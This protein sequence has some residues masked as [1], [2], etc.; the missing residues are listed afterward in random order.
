MN[1]KKIPFLAIGLYNRVIASCLTF[2][3]LV[4][5]VVR[6]AEPGWFVGKMGMRLRVQF[7][8]IIAV[9]TIIVAAENKRN[10]TV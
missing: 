4:G 1:R 7:I 9:L 2:I 3:L 6:H 5:I 8:L 10:I